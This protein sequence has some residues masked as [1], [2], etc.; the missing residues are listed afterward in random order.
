MVCLA[1]SAPFLLSDSPQALGLRYLHSKNIILRD[2]KPANALLGFDGHVRLADFGLATITKPPG[3][4]AEGKESPRRKRTS[5]VLSF[6]ARVR[7][8]SLRSVTDTLKLSSLGFG[9]TRKRSNTSAAPTN[10]ARSASW[11]LGKGIDFKRPQETVL[12]GTPGYI[13]P[14]GY[15]GRHGREGDIWA[16]GITLFEFITGV[17]RR[18][19]ANIM[20]ALS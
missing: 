12:C 8:G 10:L 9:N 16:L 5:S 11:G 7:S 1:P 14:E 3:N 17:V 20:F 4:G 13:S 15:Q 19:S 6:T 2:L 18:L